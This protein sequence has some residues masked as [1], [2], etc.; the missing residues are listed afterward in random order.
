MKKKKLIIIVFLI[1]L[2]LVGVG[3]Y[4]FIYNKDD[5]NLTSIDKQWIENNKNAIIDISVINNMP[6]FNYNGEGVLFDFL[7]DINSSTGLDFNELPYN[8]GDEVQTGL[9]LILVDETNKNDVVIYKDNYVILTK[10]NKVYNDLE[11]INSLNVGVVKSDIE[12]AKYYLKAN[13]SITYKEYNNYDAL[14]TAIKTEN[15]N[16]DGIIL[17]KLTYFK[18]IVEDDGL[19]IAYNISDMYKSL[20]LRLGEDEKLNNIM[21]KYLNKWYETSYNESFNSHYTSDYFNFKNVTEQEKTNFK[22]GKTYTYGFVSYP[23]YDSVV[24]KKLVGIN[25]EII[26]DFA[27]LNNIEISWK[28]YKTSEQ[29]VKDFNDGK[30]DFFLDTTSTLEYN[31]ETMISNTKFNDKIVVVSKNN[32]NNIK[33]LSSLKRENVATIKNSKIEESLLL[34]DIKAKTYDNISRM[35][36]DKKDTDIIVIDYLTY[37]VYKNSY[38]KDYS[39]DYSYDLYNNYKFV[40]NNMEENK[41]FNDY[42][43]FYLDFVD[44]NY[45]KSIVDSSTFKENI[46][47]KIGPYLAILALVIIILSVLF[48]SL[49]KLKTKEKKVNISKEDKIKYI[50]ALTSLKNRAYL[51]DSIEKWD[52]SE[53]YPQSI[54]VIDLNNVAYINDNYGHQEGDNLIKEAA[55]ILINNQIENTEIMRTNGNEFLIYM[56]NY[57]EKQVVTYIRKLNKDFKDLSHG[58]GAAIGYS[59]INDPIKTIDD[60]INEATLDMKNNKQELHN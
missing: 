35:L 27:A 10:A 11:D 56:V 6:V 43:M 23:P 51:N 31:V 60:A 18:Q 57:D 37:D 14:F 41:V 46:N 36:K 52:E 17:P 38:L 30:I 26:N 13:N 3:T 21:S 55:G 32:D 54:I 19:H 9:G 59:M 40:N 16:I 8:L 39:I 48:Y 2:S 53:I 34:Y 44:F 4:Y 12:N 25:Y 49:N 24:N 1:L 58:F 15:N 45:Y 33:S 50:D 28:E 29:L 47:V 20:V 42:F 5:N 7:N 22:T